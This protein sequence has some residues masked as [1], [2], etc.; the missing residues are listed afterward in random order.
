M[1]SSKTGSTRSSVSSR[2]SLLTRSS[3]QPVQ[4]VKTSI[5][6]LTWRSRRTRKSVSTLDVRNVAVLFRKN[7]GLHVAILHTLGPGGPGR[8]FS[9]I[10]PGSPGIPES[11]GN[12]GSPLAPSIPKYPCSPLSPFSPGNPVRV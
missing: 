5:S 10:I 1:N 3:L 6:F 11:P 7:T 9:P 2:F 12:P 8:P 4:S